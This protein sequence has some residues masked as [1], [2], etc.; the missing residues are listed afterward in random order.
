MVRVHARAH[1]DLL[2]L[3]VVHGEPGDGAAV[4]RAIREGSGG[5]FS[6]TPGTV[7][8]ALHRLERNRLVGRRP[9]D[10]R[11]YVLTE[12][13]RRSLAAKQREWD[14]FAHGVRALLPPQ[15]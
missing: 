8:P 13:G 9:H 5:R 1:F 4:M 3:A 10:P 11:R 12:A 2:L 7:Y 15:T 6:A 14:S